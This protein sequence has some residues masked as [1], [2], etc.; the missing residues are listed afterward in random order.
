MTLDLI[1]AMKESGFR[2]FIDMDGNEQIIDNF[3]YFADL[4]AR[5]EREACAMIASNKFN[6][7]YTKP[8]TPKDW[9]N[10]ACLNIAGAI[11]ARK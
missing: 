7:T 1:D 11:R 10:K 8:N 4:I 9:W 3:Q 6:E 5:N 2:Q